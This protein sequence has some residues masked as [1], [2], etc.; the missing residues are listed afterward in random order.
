M[1]AHSPTT[2]CPHCTPGWQTPWH[3][4]KM[5]PVHGACADEAFASAS[6]W[7]TEGVPEGISEAQR[8]PGSGARGRRLLSGAST[9][10][11]SE[12]LQQRVA[13]LERI[14]ADIK[15]KKVRAWVWLIMGAP[16]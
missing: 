15:D 6:A 4:L 8:V 7:S 9:A 5:P 10:G 14:N 12:E 2:V 13:E 16:R 3:Y 11:L 1:L